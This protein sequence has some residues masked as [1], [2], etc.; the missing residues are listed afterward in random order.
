MRINHTDRSEGTQA[1]LRL[2]AQ[3]LHAL[4]KTGRVWSGA[5][6]RRRVKVVL[7]NASPRK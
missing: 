5:E 1:L 3:S 6:V 7:T 2:L 4:K